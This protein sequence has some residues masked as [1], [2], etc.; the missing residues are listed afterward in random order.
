MRKALLFRGTGRFLSRSRLMR[1]IESFDAFEV[2]AIPSHGPASTVL[3]RRTGAVIEA[4]SK[5]K[6]EPQ[7]QRRGRVGVHHGAV[8]DHTIEETGKKM[9]QPKISRSD[10]HKQHHLQREKKA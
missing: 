6:V 5:P 7:K 2:R 9:E 8:Q 3:A 10:G 4:P 1:A